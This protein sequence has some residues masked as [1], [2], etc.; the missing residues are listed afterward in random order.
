MLE[1]TLA[2]AIG[3]LLL[4]AQ[5]HR[6]RREAGVD[7]RAVLILRAAALAAFTIAWACAEASLPGERWVRLIGGA[8]ASALAVTGLLSFA[9]GVLLRPVRAALVPF[10]RG[11][12]RRSAD[13]SRPAAA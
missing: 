4:A 2:A 11:A 10:R 6:F 1:T 9:P 7:R 5:S 12:A 3:W 13:R 8:S